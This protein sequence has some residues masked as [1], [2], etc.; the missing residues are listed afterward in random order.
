METIG[1]PIRNSRELRQA[2]ERNRDEVAEV[3]RNLVEKY[4]FTY[5][6]VLEETVRRGWQTFLVEE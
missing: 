4:G 3:G 6:L 1:A 2:I 5:P